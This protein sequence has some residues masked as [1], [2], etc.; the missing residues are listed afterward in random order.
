MRHA[1]MVILRQKYQQAPGDTDLGRQASAFAAHRVFGDLHQQGL[2]FK[3]LLFDGDL[4]LGVAG[5]ARRLAIRLAV[6]NIS[7]MQK[8]RPLQADVDKGR[9]HARQHPRDLSKVDI[10]HQTTLQCALDM[11]L[12]EHAV[13]NHGNPGL[14]G[15]PIDQYIFLHW[16]LV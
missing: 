9:L 3:Y 16:G 14:L 8:S 6:P 4:G 13:F 7:H 11:Q 1:D 15:S 12:L 10:A 2:S 5:N